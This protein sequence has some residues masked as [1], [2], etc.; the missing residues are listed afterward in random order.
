MEKPWF[1]NIVRK[2][3]CGLA[4]S[5]PKRCLPF[6]GT[7]EKS[8]F[9]NISN[10]K[11]GQ[12]LLK[13][14]DK[15]WHMIPTKYTQIPPNTVLPNTQNFPVDMLDP[16]GLPKVKKT[17]CHRLR[18]NM[19]NTQASLVTELHVCSKTIMNIKYI[20]NS[21]LREEKITTLLPCSAKNTIECK[22]DVYFLW[23]FPIGLQPII[24]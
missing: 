21:C 3:N 16:R 17:T 7:V 11:D 4:L 24:E 6:L 20:L 13:E 8:T 23:N 12:P 14:R 2:E 5:K 18:L 10:T 22:V 9:I 15:K 19:K 1:G